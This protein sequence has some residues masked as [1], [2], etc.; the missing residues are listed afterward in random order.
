MAKVQKKTRRIELDAPPENFGK[1]AK[2]SKGKQSVV[3]DGKLVLTKKAV[4]PP[5]KPR[6]AVS[7]VAMAMDT[8]LE[9]GMYEIYGKGFHGGS[10]KKFEME[11]AELGY[12]LRLGMLYGASKFNEGKPLRINLHEF[13]KTPQCAEHR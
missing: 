3:K 10:G 2:K 9:R 4:K 1:V 5:V 7:D 12:I 13:K 8:A 11:C 6:V